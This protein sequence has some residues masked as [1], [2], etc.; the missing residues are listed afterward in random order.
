MVQVSGFIDS[1]TNAVKLIKKRHAKENRTNETADTD[2]VDEDVAPVIPSASSG[3]VLPEQCDQSGCHA[4]PKSTEEQASR[5]NGYAVALMDPRDD[6][7]VSVAGRNLTVKQA[8]RQRKE[9]K[10]SILKAV[11]LS[12]GHDAIAKLD[13]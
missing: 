9:L 3:N 13:D 5:R 8:K 10:R 1:L 2:D 11:I 6:S 4:T 7:V 12:P